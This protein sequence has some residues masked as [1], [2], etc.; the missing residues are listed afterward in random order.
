MLGRAS[1]WRAIDS[2]ALLPMMPSPIAEPN[3]AKPT[4]SAKAM[5]TDATR[6]AFSMFAPLVRFVL[7]RRD[8]VC[9]RQ[10]REHDCLDESDDHIERIDEYG[11]RVRELRYRNRADR[12]VCEDDGA[13]DD[14]QHL[15]GEDVAEEP[16]RERHRPRE[17]V[18]DHDRQHRDAEAER[19][20]DEMAV[21]TEAL[22]RDADDLDE[23]DDED[24]ER[25][26]RVQIGGRRLAD[27]RE[28]PDLVEREDE[29]EQRDD[30]RHERHAV[31]A[32]DRLDLSADAVDDELHERV[33]LRELRHRVRRC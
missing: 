11:R 2:T 20:D 19:L 6:M 32:E 3:A 5:M 10:Q 9:C 13:D 28:Q 22:A 17:L 30:E 8:E 16:H 26:G 14:E 29:Q 23:D 31:T 7:K 24:S 27:E 12:D 1:G 25:S 21:V 15:A 18:D 4:I 33:A